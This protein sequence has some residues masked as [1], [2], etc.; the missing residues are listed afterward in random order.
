MER[1]NVG[2]VCAALMEVALGLVTPRTPSLVRHAS[3]KFSRNALV[4]CS[5]DNGEVAYEILVTNLARKSLARQCNVWAALLSLAE[6][7]N[8]TILTSS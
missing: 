1:M 3:L 2:V 8:L 5:M 6:V 4:L 7:A